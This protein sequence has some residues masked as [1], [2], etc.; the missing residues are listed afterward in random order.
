MSSR[1]HK[2]NINWVKRRLLVVISEDLVARA[3]YDSRTTNNFCPSQ[4]STP[5][6]STWN[7]VLV[8]GENAPF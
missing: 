8:G 1:K 7:R 3:T 5:D 4:T 6:Q 2:K